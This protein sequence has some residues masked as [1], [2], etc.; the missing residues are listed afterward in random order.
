MGVVSFVG[1]KL[2]GLGCLFVAFVFGLTGSFTG[3]NPMGWMF[4]F[5]ALV[6]FLAGLYFLKQE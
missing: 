1:N 5:I 3:N 6:L 4:L 2:L